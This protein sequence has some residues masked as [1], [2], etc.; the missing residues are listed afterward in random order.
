MEGPLASVGANARV[1]EPIL[2]DTWG[3]LYF[4]AY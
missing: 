2:M 3:Q 1:M 4:D